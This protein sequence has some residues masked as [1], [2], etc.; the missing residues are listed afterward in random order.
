[1]TTGARADETLD[2]AYC[3]RIVTPEKPD[4][5]INYDAEMRVVCGEC[6]IK[7]KVRL[8]FRIRLNGSVVWAAPMQV[9]PRLRRRIR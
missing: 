3:G 8:K 7:R 1:M 9:D 4:D 6:V 2:C 5:P